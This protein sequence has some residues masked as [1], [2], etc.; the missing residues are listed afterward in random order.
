MPKFYL[1][2]CILGAVGLSLSAC[3]AP[4]NDGASVSTVDTSKYGHLSAIYLCGDEQLQT[5]HT[6]EKTMIA[7]KGAKL[8]ASRTVQILD[9]AFAGETFTANQNGDVIVFQGKAYDATLQINN[10]VISCEKLS[11]T[12]LGENH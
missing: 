3:D 8:D 12:P 7:Y 11:C 1:T 6:A 10:D 9:N 5:S 4:A 2:Y